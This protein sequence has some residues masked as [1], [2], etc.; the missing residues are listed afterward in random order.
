MFAVSATPKALDIKEE[1][2]PLI[3]KEDQ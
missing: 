2:H 3:D 1:E